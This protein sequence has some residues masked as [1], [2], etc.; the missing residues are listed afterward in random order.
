MSDHDHDHLARAVHDLTAAAWFGG[1]LMGAVGLDGATTAAR[2][3]RERTRL[4][5]VGWN[6]WRP[7]ETC[8]LVAH[9]AAAAWLLHRSRG[10]SESLPR[11]AVAKAAV[12]VLGVAAAGYSGRLGRI[13]EAHADEGGAG[14]TEPRPGASRE[15][16]T[17]QRRLDVLQ[18]VNPA[19]AGTVVVLGAGPRRSGRVPAGD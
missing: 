16:A 14:T 6:R 12:T 3:P 18:W 7:V 10:R 9:G 4:S 17:A 15:L 11:T 13:V 1:S 19:L 5:V 2:D 8:A